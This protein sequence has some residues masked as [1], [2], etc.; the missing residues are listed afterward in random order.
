MENNTLFSRFLS[1]LKVI[2]PG[3]IISASFIGP[4]TVSTATEAG[5]SFGYALLWAILFSIVTTMILQEMA[6]RIGI[7]SGSGLGE[8]LREQFTRPVLKYATITIVG[9]SIGVG[10]AAYMAGD[11][12]GG[13][14]GI[15][16]LTGIPQNYIAPILGI[17]ILILG[18]MGTYKFFEK[19]LIVLVG[20][21]SITFI[22]TMVVVRPNVLDIFE[23]GFVPSIP[24]GSIV[25]I[26]ALIGTTVV[27]YNLF[28]HASGAHER[29]SN[30]ADLKKSRLDILIT[31]S[32]GGLITAA[33]LITSATVIRGTDV[34]GIEELALALEPTLGEWATVFIS[35]GMLAAGFSSATAASMGAAYTIGG[36]ANWGTGFDNSRFKMIFVIVISI[37]II[38][39]ATGFEPLELI[40]FA[41]A[42]NGLILPVIA[43]FVLIVVNNKNLLGQYVNSVKL[44]IIGGIIVVIASGLGI[45]SLVEAIIGFI[46]DV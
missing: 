3:A 37:G 29:W 31:I 14:L 6:A 12:T 44:N 35:I 41:Q 11:L 10:C 8:A 30:T 38:T 17:I 25:V 22:T 20:I 24:S 39:S 13:A 2:G 15:S 34:T 9:L 5:A 43:I 33:V 7:V 42:L 19:I 21:M 40:L 36:V 46:T 23:G 18:L 1:K 16:L 4:G 45:Y 26:V 27:P 32:V 28:L